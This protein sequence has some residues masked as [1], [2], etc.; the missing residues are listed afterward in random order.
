MKAACG[1]AAAPGT[2]CGGHPRSGRHEHDPGHKAHCGPAGQ[3]RGLDDGEAERAGE[4]AM[5]I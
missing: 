1:S 4:A 3:G 2:N 5:T